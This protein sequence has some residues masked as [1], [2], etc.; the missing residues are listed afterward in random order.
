MKIKNHKIIP[1]LKEIWEEKGVLDKTDFYKIYITSKKQYSRTHIENAIIN[2]YPITEELYSLII[3]YF[4]AKLKLVNSQLKKI[5]EIKN[6]TN[7]KN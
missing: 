4:D 3:T 2:S 7:S 1:A 5:K 6:A